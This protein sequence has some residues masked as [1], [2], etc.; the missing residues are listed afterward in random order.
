MDTNASWVHVYWKTSAPEQYPLPYVNRR[1]LIATGPGLPATTAVLDRAPAGGPPPRGKGF[2]DEH[3]VAEAGE[4]SSWPLVAD[5]LIVRGP[6]EREAALMA[7]FPGRL[8]TVFEGARRERLLEVA[9]E[10]LIRLVPLAAGGHHGPDLWPYASFVHAWTV[11]GRPL[12]ALHGACLTYRPP[13]RRGV[14]VS[15]VGRSTAWTAA[16]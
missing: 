8:V 14:R 15:A 6:P 7:G 10:G 11:E 12:R 3:L 9:A 16:S 2:A 1:H 5:V 4:G 13:W